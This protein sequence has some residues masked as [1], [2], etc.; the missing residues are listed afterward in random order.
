MAELGLESY[1]GTVWR[2]GGGKATKLGGAPGKGLGLR[3]KN[4][5]SRRLNLGLKTIFLHLFQQ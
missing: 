4:I 3:G 5:F 2:L 1:L